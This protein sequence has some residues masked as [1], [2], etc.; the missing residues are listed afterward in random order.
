MLFLGHGKEEGEVTYAHVVDDAENRSGAQIN[1]IGSIE[2]RCLKSQTT[3]PEGGAAASA[4][5]KRGR[6]R[7]ASPGFTVPFPWHDVSPGAGIEEEKMK[8]IRLALM[9]LCGLF[10]TQTFAQT[11]PTKP[12]HIIAPFAAG[13]SGDA[14]TR[15]V[16]DYLSKQW[17]QPVV[18]ENRAGAG[19]VIGT[20]DV[21]R[22]APDG[23]TLLMSTDGLTSLSVFIKDAGVEPRDLAP[24]SLLVRYPLALLSSTT[25]SAKTVPEVIAYAKANPGKINFGIVTNTPGHLYA[26]ALAQRAG[27]DYT[28]VP[29]AGAAALTASMLS[30]DS[31]LTFSLYGSFVAAIRDGK[32]RALAVAAA[33]RMKG[34]E[35]VPTLRENGVDLVASVWYGLFAPLNTPPAVITKINATS[36]EWTRTPAA[37]ELAAKFYMELVGSTPEEL[38]RVVAEDT[39]T[40]ATAARL[41]KIQPQ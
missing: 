26:Y 14:T 16:G 23:Y 29:Y 32:V 2:A 7:A 20:V 30:G 28:M 18:V 21:K 41:G 38:A 40:R 35:S 4:P 19:G 1:S 31:Q 22:S 8:A 3:A 34:A 15:L 13:G 33:N 36:V 37:A 10:A 39:Q 11:F 17:G 9:G 27:I 5:R 25:L 12:V 6:G 24:I